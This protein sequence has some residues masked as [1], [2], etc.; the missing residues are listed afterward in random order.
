MVALKSYLIHLQYECQLQIFNLST[1]LNFNQIILGW[2]YIQEKNTQIAPATCQFANLAET[3][4]TGGTRLKEGNVEPNVSFNLH[5]QLS[6]TIMANTST[7]LHIAP[8]NNPKLIYNIMIDNKKIFPQ[9]KHI[10]TLI[11]KKENDDVL[12]NRLIAHFCLLS[13]NFKNTLK[14]TFMALHLI[15]QNKHNFHTWWNR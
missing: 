14:T 12:I 6:K 3:T 9:L 5:N 8:G 10:C 1:S 4:G 7:Y 13:T 15:Y 2:S 11:N